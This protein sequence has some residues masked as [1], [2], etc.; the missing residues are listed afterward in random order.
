MYVNINKYEVFEEPFE[1]KKMSNK[2]VKNY[3]LI[4]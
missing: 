1:I 2:I 4:N 3:N